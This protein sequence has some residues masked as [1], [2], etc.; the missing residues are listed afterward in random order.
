M[1]RLII[2]L[3]A[4]AAIGIIVG[5]W[6]RGAPLLGLILGG[7]VIEAAWNWWRLRSSAEPVRGVADRLALSMTILAL[8]LASAAPWD[9]FEA[10]LGVN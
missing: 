4:M 1:H 2:A 5:Q 9:Q 3:F 10:W 8:A 7:I 6:F